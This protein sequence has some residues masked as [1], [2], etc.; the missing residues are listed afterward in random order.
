MP[1]ASSWCVTLT[2]WCDKGMRHFVVDQL[3]A[4]TLFYIHSQLAPHP[5]SLPAA[6][7]GEA[8]KCKNC[9]KFVHAIC[10]YEDK[11]EANCEEGYRKSVICRQCGEEEQARNASESGERK[12]KKDDVQ[13]E[14]NNTF[15]LLSYNDSPFV[16]PKRENGGHQHSV[17]GICVACFESK[18]KQFSISRD[19][20]SQIERQVSTIHG[21]KKALI[22]PFNDPRARKA[23]L[24]LK[25][26]KEKERSMQNDLKYIAKL[27]SEGLGKL[28][29]TCQYLDRNTRTAYHSYEQ[30]RNSN[31]MTK[32]K[33][34]EAM[35]RLTQLKK[36][37]RSRM[38]Q[39]LDEAINRSLEDVLEMDIDFLTPNEPNDATQDQNDT[40]QDDTDKEQDD[41]DEEQNSENT[42]SGND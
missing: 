38:D 29:K 26:Q 24:Q 15:D 41:A 22:V 21:G 9:R 13:T 31:R 42:Q 12:Q 1:F 11:G 6:T 16:K 32:A 30:I 33:V 40:T 20:K 18:R 8:H 3:A 25:Q 19:N 2:T 17:Q 34:K 37:L 27:A 35:A 4:R 10:R 28:E 14:A 39:E 36:V 23:Q 5:F 7:L